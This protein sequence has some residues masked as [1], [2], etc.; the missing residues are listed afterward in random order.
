M[1]PAFYDAG[2]RALK[3][4]PG[5]RSELVEAAWNHGY[6]S[7]R[8]EA[9]GWLYFASDIGV[10]GE[11][12]LAVADGGGT[13]F[14]SVDHP[15]VA[16]E[17]IAAPAM[18]IPA[19]KRGAFGFATQREMRRAISRAYDLARSLPTLPLAEFEAEA[20]ELRAT[21]VDAIVRRRVGQD[22]FRRA[23]MRYWDGRCPITGITEPALL[24]ASHI[25]P[26]AEC[27]S[28]A[29][30]LNVHNGLLLAAHWDAAFDAGLLGF[31]Y[32]GRAVVRPNLD[33]ATLTALAIP[34]AAPLP[35]T[36]AHR[37]RLAWHLA[38]FGLEASK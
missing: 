25:V 34:R 7:E 16:A 23:L 17:L 30:R 20:A 15:G 11:I 14:L 22:V 6:R 32:D 13:W 3:P 28:D 1:A 38:R 9:N 4:A 18:P 33:D 27:A 35:L 12:G 19:G 29:E 36:D 8:G 26:W 21:E 31:G 24:R 2:H 5:L 37:S 10:P